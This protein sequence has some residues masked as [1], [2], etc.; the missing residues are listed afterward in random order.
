MKIRGMAAKAALIA[1]MAGAGMAVTAAPAAAL[2]NDDDCSEVWA[3]ISGAQE[4]MAHSDTQYE[5]WTWFRAWQ[6]WLSVASRFC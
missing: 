2:A 1:V 4:G 5:F 6:T 3:G